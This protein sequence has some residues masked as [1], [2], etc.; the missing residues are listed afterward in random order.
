MSQD[1]YQIQQKLEQPRRKKPKK[2]TA[3]F[4]VQKK[5]LEATGYLAKTKQTK[6]KR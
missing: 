5:V 1:L 6:K 4:A 3:G 2:V